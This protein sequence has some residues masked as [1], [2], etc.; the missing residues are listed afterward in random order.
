MDQHNYVGK[1]DPGPEYNPCNVSYLGNF[2]NTSNRTKV[3]I[4]FYV[5]YVPSININ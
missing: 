4:P 3:T 2:I 1:L 5:R